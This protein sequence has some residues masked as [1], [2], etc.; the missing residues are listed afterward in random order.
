MDSSL[1]VVKLS[2]SLLRQTLRNITDAL[3]LHHIIFD[4]SIPICFSFHF[5]CLIN[6]VSPLNPQQGILIEDAVFIP[7]VIFTSAFGVCV[8]SLS[9]LKPAVLSRAD[10]ALRVMVHSRDIG[11]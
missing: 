9:T 10:A 6:N 1:E 11:S 8:K 2:A 3:H 4:G 5:Q 7:L